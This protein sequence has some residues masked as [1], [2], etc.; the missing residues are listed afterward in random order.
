MGLAAILA[1]AV[2]AAA[3]HAGL[4]PDLAKAAQ[5]YDRAQVRCDKAELERL[6]AP[7]YRL[8]NSGGQV[9]DKASFIADST[10]P[11]FRMSPFTVEEPL[12]RMEGPDLALL[13]GVA[14]LKGSSAGRPFTA[15]LRFMDVWAR[16]DGRWQVVFTQATRV[17]P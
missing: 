7:D 3:L 4:P 17:A 10:A 14:T 8:F 15:R 2:T 9:Q 12:E 13:G 6:L 5:D 11:T 1:A 16:R